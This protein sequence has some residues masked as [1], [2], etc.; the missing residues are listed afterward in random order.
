MTVHIMLGKDRSAFICVFTC[1]PARAEQPRF[2][3]DTA[4]LH[5]K[6]PR[7]QGTCR[8]RC[9]L[10]PFSPRAAG[11]TL[12]DSAQETYDAHKCLGSEISKFHL[13]FT[14]NSRSSISTNRAPEAS[15]FKAF[16][17]LQRFKM[18]PANQKTLKFIPKGRVEPIRW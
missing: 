7:P 15:A 4:A 9:P 12:H 11:A 17:E 6:C 18:Q 5:R 13:Q 16:T 1:A 10:S 14:R 2:F 3:E 8:P